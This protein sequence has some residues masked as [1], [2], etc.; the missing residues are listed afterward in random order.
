MLDLITTSD[1]VGAT[2]FKGGK[3]IGRFSHPS[4]LCFRLFKSAL[5]MVRTLPSLF[6]PATWLLSPASIPLLPN[7]LAGLF[8]PQ[9]W[10]SFSNRNICSYQG[11]SVDG[12]QRTLVKLF[13]RGSN[14]WDE[15]VWRWIAPL[16]LLVS[17]SIFVLIQWIPL[18]SNSVAV[19]R[20][21]PLLSPPNWV[22]LC[23]QGRRGDED[24]NILLLF[25]LLCCPLWEDWVIFASRL[26]AASSP[27]NNAY[28]LSNASSKDLGT[29]A[30]ISI[31]CLVRIPC[32]KPDIRWLP[33]ALAIYSDFCLYRSMNSL[34]LSPS[35]CLMLCLKL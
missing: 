29:Q 20:T 11:L 33:S 24:E 8:L 27:I 22:T 12:S 6:F 3:V 1:I 7:E 30:L 25:L 13:G 34:R 15:V 28:I 35:F 4:C 9:P 18:S 21:A 17:L 23:N 14:S 2:V 26:W 32:T 16:P 31:N 19:C 10:S 5:S